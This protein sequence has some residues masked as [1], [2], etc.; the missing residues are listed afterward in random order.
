MSHVRTSYVHQYSTRQT[1][2]VCLWIIDLSFL[3][4]ISFHLL[5]L[6][7]SH[8]AVLCVVWPVRLARSVAGQT[9]LILDAAHRPRCAIRKLAV[10]TR[11]RH[12]KHHGKCIY[13]SLSLAFFRSSCPASFL[14]C[15]AMCFTVCVFVGSLLW[16]DIIV[17]VFALNQLNR[18]TI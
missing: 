2:T 9:I 8:C 3:N 16:H 1:N 7:V 13:L 17:Y 10:A 4:S 15:F 12:L 14:F 11:R 5:N 6:P 18:N